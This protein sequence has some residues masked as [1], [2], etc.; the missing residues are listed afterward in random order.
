M[1][2]KS[3]I[4]LTLFVGILFLFSGCFYIADKDYYTDASDYLNIWQLSGFRHGDD[5][6]PPL[7]PKSIDELNIKSFYC[8]Y[9]QQLPLGEGFQIFLNIQYD[10]KNL[11]D[12]ELERIVSLSFDCS[13]YFEQSA[14]SAYA[15]CLGKNFSFIY[16]LADSEQQTIYYIYLQNLPKNEIEFSHQFLPNGYMGYGEINNTT[17]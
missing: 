2:R 8:R 3:M 10:D 11:F 4:A 1:C 14:F 16:A 6:S 12:S 17:E 5:G 9:D 7:F 13:E 15:T